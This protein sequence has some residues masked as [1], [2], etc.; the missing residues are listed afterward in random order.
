MPKE[1]KITSEILTMLES[2]DKEMQRLGISLMGYKA[3][4]I[5][6]FNHLHD[7]LLK[8]NMFLTY[9]PR[10][11]YYYEAVEIETMSLRKYPSSTNSQNKWKPTGE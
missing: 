11:G 1:Y 10:I 5:H 8:H 2:Q 9:K 4:T 3:R 6:D 7:F